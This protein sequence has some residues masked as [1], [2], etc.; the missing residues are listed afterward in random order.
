MFCR[1]FWN[2]FVALCIDGTTLCLAFKQINKSISDIVRF[3]KVVDRVDEVVHRM[4]QE[5]YI[6]HCRIDRM[7]LQDIF[8]ELI[9]EGIWQE[10]DKMHP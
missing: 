7:F 1:F 2:V 9:N 6:H 4:N 3:D 5:R 8:Q 10:Y